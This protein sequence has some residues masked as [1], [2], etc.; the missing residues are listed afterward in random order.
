MKSFITLL[1]LS[2]IICKLSAQYN[3]YEFIDTGI[4]HSFEPKLT[5]IVIYPDAR[6]IEKCVNK[7]WLVSEIL[8]YDNEIAKDKY[9]KYNGFDDSFVMWEASNS[10]VT[11]LER[12]FIKEV[13]MK[14]DFDNNYMIFRPFK[15]KLINS[16]HETTFLNVLV[17]GKISIYVYRHIAYFKIED[18]PQ[19]HYQ[20]IIKKEDGSVSIFKPNKI[21]LLAQFPDKKKELKKIISKNR[22][23]IRKE[24][25][26]AKA[27]EIFNSTLT[28]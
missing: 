15:M 2:L 19:P 23:N 16:G 8:L 28:D 11:R 6:F 25:D 10:K 3:T 17:E 14:N 22:L 18:S 13:K 20:F 9:L 27:I 5:G 1:I 4:V 12:E 21:S 24:S 26:L 7:D